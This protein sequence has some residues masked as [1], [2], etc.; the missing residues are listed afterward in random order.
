MESDLT[1]VR[2]PYKFDENTIDRLLE[3]G[4]A[5]ISFV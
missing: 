2:V 5:I 4:S 1:L 3:N